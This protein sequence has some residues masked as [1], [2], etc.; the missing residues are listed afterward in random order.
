MKNNYQKG[1][2]ACPV[3]NQCHQ[4]KQG[5]QE[6]DYQKIILNTGTLSLC[7]ATKLRGGSDI[8][9]SISSSLN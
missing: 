3:I 8:K 7:V 2:Q 4:I 1:S 6:G 5:I 9:A